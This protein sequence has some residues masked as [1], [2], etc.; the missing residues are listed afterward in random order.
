MLI[1][2]VAIPGSGKSTLAATLV[3]EGILHPD[4]IVSPDRY[5]EILTGDRANQT[6]NPEAWRMT[7]MVGLTRLAHNQDVYLDATNVVRKN[8]SEYHAA[9]IALDHRV[10]FVWFDNT[11]QAW[12]RNANRPNDIRVPEHA[13]ERMY[14]NWKNLDMTGIT[15][16]YHYDDPNL[17]DS[18]RGIA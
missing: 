6:V 4:A 5:R 2:P 11:E 8:W 9:A 7:A 14:Q 12:K 13:M 15:D 1:I 3:N 17:F 18:L 10:V 16:Q